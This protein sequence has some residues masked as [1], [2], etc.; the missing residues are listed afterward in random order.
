MDTLERDIK[1]ASSEATFN[2]ILKNKLLRNSNI[3][4]STQTALI[5]IRGDIK[6]NIDKRK[7]TVLLLLDFSRAFDCVHHEL[8]LSILES[9]SFSQIFVKWVRCYLNN[10]CQEIKTGSALSKCELNKVGVPQGSRYCISFTFF[11]IY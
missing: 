5:K 11:F 9:Y 3:Y 7:L 6:Y 4:F 8:L 1:Q 10:R 2:K